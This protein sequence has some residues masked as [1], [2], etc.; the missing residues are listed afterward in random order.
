M[1]KSKFSSLLLIFG[2]A[3]SAHGVENNRIEYDGLSYEVISEGEHTVSVTGYLGEKFTEKPKTVVVP[4]TIT[5]GNSQYTVTAI[6][7]EAFHEC[8]DIT[9][10]TVPETIT[11]IGDYAFSYCVSLKEMHIP[12]SVKSI[13]KGL[14]QDCWSLSGIDIPEGLTEIPDGMYH[15]CDKLEKITIPASITKIGMSAFGNCVGL[16]EIIFPETLKEIDDLAFINCRRLQAVTLP[17]SLV[18]LG[19]MVFSDDESIESLSLPASLDSIGIGAFYNCRS[20]KTIYSW[21][22]NPPVLK[23]EWH[24]VGGD[25]DLYPVHSVFGNVPADAVVYVPAGSLDLYKEDGEWNNCFSDFREMRGSGINDVITETGETGARYYNLNGV[26]L[27]GVP[28]EAGI[29]V[30]HCDGKSS[31]VIVR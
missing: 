26:C 9:D 11:E 7:D 2:L 24:P 13:G 12:A 3:F 16:K 1:A 20:L 15:A 28:T 10:L 19:S 29:Y 8:R 23:K 17:S 21:A 5:V 14:F 31:K 18:K 25:P 27:P 30:K 4:A 22:P 6:G